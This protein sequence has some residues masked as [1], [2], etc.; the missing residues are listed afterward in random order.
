ML[1][2]FHKIYSVINSIY[3][4][5]VLFSYSTIIIYD[6]NDI[7]QYYKTIDYYDPN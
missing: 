3:S 6:R 5:Q 1:N 2:D 4:G 7:S